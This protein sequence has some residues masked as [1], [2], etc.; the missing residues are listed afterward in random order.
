M[1]QGLNEGYQKLQVH[2]INLVP[3]KNLNG[4]AYIEANGRIET[5][6]NKLYMDGRKPHTGSCGIIA[7]A[8]LRSVR[9]IFDTSTPSI[10]TEPDE[11]STKRYKAED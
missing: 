11:S 4:L 10:V 2:W 1:G 5:L 9:P 6:A 3:D 8:F 7:R